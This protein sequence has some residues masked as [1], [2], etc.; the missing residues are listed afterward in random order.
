MAEYMR[1]ELMKKDLCKAATTIHR[2]KQERDEYKIAYELQKEK[3]TNKKDLIRSTIYLEE[4]QS[5]NNS[6]QKE[7][8]HCK[9]SIVDKEKTISKLQ[10]Q[11]EAINKKLKMDIESFRDIE[12]ARRELNYEISNSIIRNGGSSIYKEIQSLMKN[13]F[14]SMKSNPSIYKIF[15]NVV[16]CTKKFKLEIEEENYCKGFLVMCKF[17][18]N[19]LD[20]FNFCEDSQNETKDL[21]INTDEVYRGRNLN[22]YESQRS[23]LYRDEYNLRS[24]DRSPEN[25]TST[26]G[27][28]TYNGSPS[29]KRHKEDLYQQSLELDKINEKL[30]KLSMSRSNVQSRNNRYLDREKQSS[31]KISFNTEEKR[32]NNSNL[33]NRNFGNSEKSLT[34]DQ[35]MM[36]DDNKDKSVRLESMSSTSKNLKSVSKSR[37]PA[38]RLA[39]PRTKYDEY[40]SPVLRKTDCSK[41]VAE[42]LKFC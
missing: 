15:K 6:L 24:Y 12:D 7:L 19:L 8:S 14:C 42:A 34:L 31:S 18:I 37:S 22:T 39:S 35:N 28:K 29:I 2:L 1:F 27:K 5:T 25:F 38:R 32:G 30:Q 4:L 13:L 10:Q 33:M 21:D 3:N 20:S 40:M 17:A 11:Y 26:F 36:V 16:Q 41:S 9:K 23:R